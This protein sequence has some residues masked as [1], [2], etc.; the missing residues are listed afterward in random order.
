MVLDYPA[1]QIVTESS[2]TGS[3]APVRR[4]EGNGESGGER[5][6]ASAVP[7]RSGRDSVDLLPL[8]PFLRDQRHGGGGSRG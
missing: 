2:R 1:D 8:L 4:S 7:R 3:V 5:V 6:A